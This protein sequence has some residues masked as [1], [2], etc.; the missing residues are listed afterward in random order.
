MNQALRR[1]R[2]GALLLGLV[3]VFAIVSHNATTNRPLLESIYWTV[4]TIAGVG[5]SQEVSATTG[6]MLQLICRWP[7]PWACLFKPLS[8]ANSNKLWE[9][10]A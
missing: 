1:A 2:Q 4:I 3:F 10:D 5:Y 7:T 8:K 9:I 6:P